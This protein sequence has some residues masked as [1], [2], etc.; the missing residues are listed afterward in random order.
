M[1]IKNYNSSYPLVSDNNKRYKGAIKYYQNNYTCRNRNE[2][3]YP[4]MN[5]EQRTNKNYSSMLK[6]QLFEGQL[7]NKN[8]NF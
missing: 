4:K 7:L 5:N 3:I 6:R 8:K 1:G 2:I